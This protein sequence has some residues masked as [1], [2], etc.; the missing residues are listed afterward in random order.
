MFHVC[1]FI[2]DNNI[3]P[4]FIYL[5]CS[6]VIMFHGI[7]S[8]SCGNDQ[9]G[10]GTAQSRKPETNA[11]KTTN[12]KNKIRVTGEFR[13]NMNQMTVAAKGN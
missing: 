9:T 6:V 13:V 7:T 11:S 5:V 3:F 2:D 8:K 12:R 1:N 10:P 4:V